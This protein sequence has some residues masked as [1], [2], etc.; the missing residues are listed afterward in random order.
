MKI[1]INK[2]IKN[3]PKIKKLKIL[4]AKLSALSFP[5]LSSDA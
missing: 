2:T 4:V 5:L 3:K 1:S